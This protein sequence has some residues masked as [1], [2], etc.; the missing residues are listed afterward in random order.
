M[1]APA[2]HLST[3]FS[4]IIQNGDDRPSFTK[5]HDSLLQ[6]VGDADYSETVDD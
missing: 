2:Y 3:R 4:V 5:L 1:S 6:M